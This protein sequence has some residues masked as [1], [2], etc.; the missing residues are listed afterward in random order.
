M[1]GADII[2]A[3]LRA[4]SSVTA[5][6]PVARIRAAL[7]PDATPLPALLVRTVS[8]IER[9]HLRRAVP[10]TSERVSVAVRAGNYQDQ[11]EII[12]LVRECC[13]GL[14]GALGPAPWAS[15]EYDSTSPDL[16]GPAATFEQTIDFTVKFT[17]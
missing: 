5:K 6:V 12:G 10:L 13:A 7:L 17:A 2:G 1:T 14:T 8:S 3:L 4:D 9:R 15:V 11:V 16:I